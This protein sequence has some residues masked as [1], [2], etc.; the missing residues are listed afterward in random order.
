MKRIDKT[1]M[2]QIDGGNA[3]CT[4][5][6]LYTGTGSTILGAANIYAASAGLVAA[7]PAGVVVG[8]GAVA[9]AAA[10]CSALS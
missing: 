9:T 1:E 3:A 10:Y 4:A 8:L 2:A 5:A 6:G 7:A